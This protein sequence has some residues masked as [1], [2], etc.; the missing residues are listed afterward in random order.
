ME[1][2]TFKPRTKRP[3]ISWNDAIR[4]YKNTKNL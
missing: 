2:K 3:T 4:L 1:T